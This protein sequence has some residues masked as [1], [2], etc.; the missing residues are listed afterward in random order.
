M[1]IPRKLNASDDLGNHSNRTYILAFLLCIQY[2]Q[3]TQTK[4]QASKQRKPC[5]RAG[6]PHL[7]VDIVPKMALH[8]PTPQLPPHPYGSHQ[9]LLQVS[10]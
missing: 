2:K 6:S 7:D 9:A 4:S 3:K 10:L 1:H 8:T 5:R